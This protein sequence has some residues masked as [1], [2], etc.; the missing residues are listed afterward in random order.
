MNNLDFLINNINNQ[1]LSDYLNKAGWNDVENDFGL[2]YKIFQNYKNDE[3]Y[4]IDVPFLDNCSDYKR[5]ISSALETLS[6]FESLPIGNVVEKIISQKAD[7]IKIKSSNKNIINGSIPLDEG[8]QFFE[9]TKK[10]IADAA[11]DIL[12]KNKHRTSKYTNDV[13]NFL[14]KCRFGQTEIGSY[15]VSII[16]PNEEQNDLT[17]VSLFDS[18]LVGEGLGR[19]VIRKVIKSTEEI[20]KALNTG[21]DLKE[22]LYN[23]DDDF[24]GLNFIEDLTFFN[25]DEDS[26][27]EIKTD[28]FNEKDAQ[29]ETISSKFIL[30]ENKKIKKFVSDYKEAELLDGAPAS[31]SGLISKVAADPIIE[32]RNSGE[33]TVVSSLDNKQ[34]KVI[35][36]PDDYVRAVSAHNKGF[37]VTIN[38][39]FKDGNIECHDLY[40]HEESS[41]FE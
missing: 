31:V 13:N 10:I 6:D 1:L 8:L 19:R 41:L 38:G 32:N 29:I 17:E 37:R 28:L 26:F 15:V 39:V 22:F 33:G 2:S 14:S 7:I 21:K 18:G 35:F 5:L 30:K 16:C 25:G 23:N 34:Y 9:I 11:S 27:I 12:V 4:Q 20:S 24:I 36:G 3:L 40:V